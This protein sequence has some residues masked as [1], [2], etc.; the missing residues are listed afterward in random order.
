[1]SKFTD[2]LEREMFARGGLNY[3]KADLARDLG[4][5]QGTVS[6]WWTQDR[7]PDDPTLREIGRLFMADLGWI[8]T[9]L[10]GKPP[11]AG[12][13]RERERL[14]GIVYNL[15]EGAKK[16]VLKDA[17]TRYEKEKPSRR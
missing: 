8:Y 2:W 17:Q 13:D 5:K 15:S 4:V 1:M 3:R 16:A 6:E 11:P 10:I 9:D 12:I 14:I 7:T